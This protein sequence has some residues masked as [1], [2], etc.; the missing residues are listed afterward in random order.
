MRTYFEHARAVDRGL[1]YAAER[2]EARHIG[3]SLRRIATGEFRVER[4]RTV[5]RAPDLFARDSG[6]VPRLAEFVAANG[7]PPPLDA[8]P[9]VT[10]AVSSV[11]RFPER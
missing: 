8:R 1:R 7:I 4:D 10:W 9:K 11:R 3:V 6:A 2:L 5:L